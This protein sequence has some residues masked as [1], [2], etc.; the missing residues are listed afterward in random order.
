[1]GC[2]MRWLRGAGLWPLGSFSLM[3]K[4][5]GRIVVFTRGQKLAIGGLIFFVLMLF[6]VATRYIETVALQSIQWAGLS[7]APD[8]SKVAQ[9]ASVRAFYSQ[10]IGAV[11]SAFVGFALI[12]NLFL[13]QKSIVESSKKNLND[14]FIKSIELLGS[15]KASVRLAALSTLHAQAKDNPEKSTLIANVI[16]GIVKDR[17]NRDSGNPVQLLLS[18]APNR[19]K[20][21][22]AETELQAAISAIGSVA[23]LVEGWQFDLSRTS[24]EGVWFRSLDFNRFYFWDCDF[25]KCDFQKA[26]FLS[27]DFTDSHFRNCDFSG[28]VFDGANF[29]GSTFDNDC[30]G[31]TE[32]FFKKTEGNLETKI[33]NGI[34]APKG[35][36]GN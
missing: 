13:T 3:V 10:G 29:S 18:L 35:W 2:W 23:P 30:K 22:L 31:L 25:Q 28:A 20:L 33:P 4:R 5:G 27:A 7:N 26:N 34:K 8:A 16:C 11:F 17:Y 36:S 1:M 21:G 6:Y 14:L 32:S 19:Q 24:L 9:M 12:V 15:D